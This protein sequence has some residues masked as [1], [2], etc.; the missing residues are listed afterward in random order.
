MAFGTSKG[1]NI[2]LPLSNMNLQ[3]YTIEDFLLDEKFVSWVIDRQHEEY[4]QEF[5]A[6]YPEKLSLM[7]QARSIIQAT[8]QLPVRRL[9]SSDEIA[10]WQKI[11]ER[12]R[13]STTSVVPTRRIGQPWWWVAAAS[14]LLAVGWFA[15]QQFPLRQQGV[16]YKQLVAEIAAD[17][18]IEN[19]NQTTIPKLVILPDGSSVLLHKGSKLSYVDNE[20]NLT[21][22][23]VYLSGEAFFEVKKNSEKPFFVFSNE[24][25]IKVLGTSFTIRAF[26]NNEQVEVVVKTGKVSVF[27]QSDPK[28]DVKLNDWKLDGMVLLPNQQVVLE[29]S[30][31]RMSK[32]LI[33]KPELLTLPAQRLSFEF[34]DVLVSDAV[35]TL[36]KAYGVEIIY[37]EELLSECRLTAHLADEPLFD[38]VQ[39][40]CEALEAHYEVI[41][42]RIIIHAK[43]CK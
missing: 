9:S 40:I 26:D 43:G 42:A 34:D 8:A 31:L 12:I 19:E 29:R 2:T 25:V 24:L 14:V 30:E 16:T 17:R 11:Q 3:N 10:M 15:W 32:S 27:T 18:L 21:K 33:E 6:E 5:L 39:M 20:F 4:W 23:E 35:S 1:E 13:D 38:K 37:D 28:K 7:Q 22:R 36:E 41:D